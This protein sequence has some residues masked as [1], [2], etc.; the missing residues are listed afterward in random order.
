VIR[1]G[2]LWHQ[3]KTKTA[4]RLSARQASGKN[5]LLL[6]VLNGL[7]KG[8]PS[9]SA[10]GHR[11]TGTETREPGTKVYGEFIADQLSAQKAR[12]DSFERRG[13]AVVTSAGVLVTLLF[14]LASLSTTEKTLKL[15]GEAK[16]LLIIAL[17]AF[18]VAAVLA[19]ATNFP[20]P[21]EV[22]RA[23]ALKQRLK[24]RPVRDEEAALRD[25]AVTRANMLRRAK[26]MNAIKGWFLIAALAAEV[27]AV[28]VVGAAIFEAI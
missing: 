6:L 19:L 23:E 10:K 7:R 3:T 11:P 26:T 5:G 12:Q 4:S 15:P 24:A 17:V 20:M 2:A 22:P 14:G 1:S 25:I 13:L 9:K 27:T 28:G 21:Y 18:V 16:E 8:N